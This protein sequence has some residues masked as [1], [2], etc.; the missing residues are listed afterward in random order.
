MSKKVIILGGGV[1]G[2]SAAHELI[3]R[4]FDVDVYEWGSVP[5]G[6]ARSMPVLEPM[7]G[8]G[9]HDVGG[10]VFENAPRMSG[11]QAAAQRKLP[12]LPGEHG[13]RFFPGFYRHIIDTMDRI[14]YGKGKVSDNF[15]NT[16][17][18][19]FARYGGDSTVLPS[20]FPKTPEE[21]KSGLDF[22]QRMLSGHKSLPLHEI[23]FFAARVWQIMTSCEERRLQEY[24]KIGWWDFIGAAERSLDYQKY[25]A[26]GF[27]RS[28]VASQAQLASTF[29]VGNMHLQMLFDVADPTIPTSDRLLNGP[30]N[31]VWI[32][33][34]LVYM[35]SLGLKYH[36]NCDVESIHFAAGMVRN[37]TIQHRQNGSRSQV[38]GD[39]YLAALPVEHMAPLVTRSMMEADP[40]LAHLP[41]L[42]KNVAWMN[43]I[44][45]Y[46][47]RPLPIAHGHVIYVDSPWALTS[48]SQGQ[49]WSEQLSRYSDGDTGDIISVD[50][51]DWNTPGHNG[52]PARD[53]TFLEIKEEVWDQ[54]KRSLNVEGREILRV[55][56]L[57]SW[58]LDPDIILDPEDYEGVGNTEPLLVNLKDT[59]RLR[60]EAVT[61]IPNLFLASDYV[62]TYT[63]LAT[64][65]GAN[66]AARRA[67]NG[68]IAASGTKA[69]PCSLWKLHEP[70]IFQPLRDYDRTRWEAGLPWDDR[71]VSVALSVLEFVQK[72]AG[73]SSGDI[74][75]VSSATSRLGPT[76]GYHKV[77]SESGS[78]G[79]QV[80][81]QVSKQIL[82]L[83]EDVPFRPVMSS[84]VEKQQSTPRTKLAAEETRGST[85]AVPLPRRGRIRIVQ[86]QY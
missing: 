55:Q 5:G 83:V 82:S 24:E 57:D 66:E 26:H 45:F 27:T 23:E 22:I 47:T 73:L 86:K 12:W 49:F 75:Y 33:P 63:D 51:S 42:A 53:C 40:Q 52:K 69:S 34:W 60:P 4:G 62:R 14:P 7:G 67:V 85:A 32:H 11:D 18:V 54:L 77:S 48:V 56:D 68:I 15:V 50:I 25:F 35:E 9:N 70:E 80:L 59:W 78:T 21:I 46:I 30:T 61:A 1:A 16:T 44:Q 79:E 74:G 41:E 38:R 36:F 71:W 43:G 13:F 17:Q 31:D 81:L 10:R 29:T 20:H 19:A 58:F 72:A 76:T 39:Y 3:E 65:E 64:M 6:K 37:V 28:L 2:M 8:S 84:D